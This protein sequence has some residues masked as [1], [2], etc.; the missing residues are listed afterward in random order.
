MTC[1]EDGQYAHKLATESIRGILSSSSRS[2][3]LAVGGVERPL[4][5]T[6]GVA[7]SKC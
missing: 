6:V 3:R 1:T 5:L 2:Y 7:D 4:I